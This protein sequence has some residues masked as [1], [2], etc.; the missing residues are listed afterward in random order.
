[1]WILL[2][3]SEEPQVTRLRDEKTAAVA[4]P[5]PHGSLPRKIEAAVSS[6][7]SSANLTYRALRNMWILLEFSE[8]P[9]GEAA[10]E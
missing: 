1:M 2:E 6:S 3:L 9:Q 8:E 5:G 10:Q 4:Q 7:I